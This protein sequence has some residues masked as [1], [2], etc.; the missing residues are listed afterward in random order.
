MAHPNC[1]GD[2][3]LT[4]NQIRLLTNTFEVVQI[5]RSDRMS[6]LLLQRGPA[7]VLIAKGVFAQ[8]HRSEV[9]WA[10]IPGYLALGFSREELK[11]DLPMDVEANP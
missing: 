3:Y 6:L 8:G 1:R 5:S 11:L 2:I 4:E 7:S 9:T 10:N